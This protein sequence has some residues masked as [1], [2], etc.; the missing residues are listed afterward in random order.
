MRAAAGAAAGLERRWAQEGGGGSM[1]L[2]KE[3]DE[4]QGECDGA[5]HPLFSQKSDL[6]FE[7]AG[8][9][10]TSEEDWKKKDSGRSS[11]LRAY[12]S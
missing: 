7:W 5:R 1:L 6:S 4:Q 10:K 9:E 11:C 8:L 2:L 12:G 3:S